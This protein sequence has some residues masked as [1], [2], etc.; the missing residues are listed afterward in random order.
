MGVFDDV[1]KQEETLFKDETALDYDFL[2]KKL[3]NREGE[4]DHL[5]SCIKPLFHD[6]NGKNLFIHGPPGIGKTAAARHVLMELEEQTESISTV[7]VNCWQ[8]NTSY[9]VLVDICDE[10]G[11]KFTQNK[12]TGELL[13]VIAKIADKAVFVFDEIDKVDDL[14]FLYSILEETSKKSIFLITNYKSWLS[15]LDERIKSRL[16][17]E[18]VVFDQYT[19]QETKDILA[20]RLGYAFYDGVW[21]DDAFRKA[22]EKAF[23][24]KDIRSG[25]FLL[26]EAGDIAESK[27]KKKIELEHVKKATE[28]LEDFTIKNSAS[29]EE[30]TQLVYQVVKEN[31]KEKIGVLYEKYKEKG[32]TGS[33]KTFQRKISKLEEGRFLKT[34]RQVGKGGNT[35]I[36]EKN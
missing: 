5:A 21:M 30:D 7:Y 10:L 20:D 31:S 23:E 17:P 11:Y 18:I 32:G 9:K 29:L 27:S 36:V 28:K 16:T 15:E 6:R 26:K 1:L 2:P 4:Q 25:L 14:N 34:K 24:L 22:V 19:Y 8:K 33:Y 35:T 3:P 12:Q 13:K